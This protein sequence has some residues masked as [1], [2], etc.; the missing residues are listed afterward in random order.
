MIFG[1]SFIK[2]SEQKNERRSSARKD[3]DFT[4]RFRFITP[5]PLIVTKMFNIDDN[6]IGYVRNVSSGGILFE[7]PVTTKGLSF[8]YHLNKALETSQAEEGIEK[9]LILKPGDFSTVELKITSADKKS[10]VSLL[11]LPVWVKYVEINDTD[12]VIRLGLRFPENHDM[13]PKGVVDKLS[14]LMD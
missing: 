1:I 9:S 10:S 8:L 14:R 7:I 5:L 3:A 13:M 11:G 2:D 12:G 4:A 6:G